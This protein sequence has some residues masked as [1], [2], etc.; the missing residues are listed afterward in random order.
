LSPALK[1][2]ERVRKVNDVLARSRV[3]VDKI[4]RRETAKMWAAWQVQRDAEEKEKDAIAK[5]Y[6]DRDPTISEEAAIETAQWEMRQKQN[7]KIQKS[8]EVQKI[9]DSMTDEQWAALKTSLVKDSKKLQESLGH[10]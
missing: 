7:A 6:M 10:E 5:K 3:L 2:K 8:R 1:E 4:N 9:R